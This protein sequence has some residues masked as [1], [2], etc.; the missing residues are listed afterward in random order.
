MQP[1][2]RSDGWSQSIATGA[3]TTARSRPTT[4]RRSTVALRRA[5]AAGRTTPTGSRSMSIRSRTRTSRADAHPIRRASPIS[6]APVDVPAWRMRAACWSR[7][8]GGLAGGGA[9]AGRAPS[10]THSTSPTTAAKLAPVLRG[11]LAASVTPLRDGGA[12]IDE[13]GFGPVADFLHAGGLDGLL[14]LGTN[15]EG[16]LLSIPERKR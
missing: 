4:R 1:A 12:A 13:D 11:A 15:G 6:T 14:A 3:T 16:I 5:R 2:S 10:R 7:H 9:G 8:F